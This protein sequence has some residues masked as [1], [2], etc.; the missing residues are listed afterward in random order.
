MVLRFA[1]LAALVL[2]GLSLGACG[3]KGSLG[4]KEK[5]TTT[6]TGRTTR[7]T[8]GDDSLEDDAPPPPP[9]L[10]DPIGAGAGLHHPGCPSTTETPTSSGVFALVA[11]PGSGDG[12]VTRC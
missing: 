12:S 3:T 1:G 4:F 8:R 10:A 9:D 7:S 6:T 5:G 2:L 11:P